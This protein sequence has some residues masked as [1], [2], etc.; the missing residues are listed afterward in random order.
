[1]NY[2]IIIPIFNEEHT[3]NKLLSELKHYYNKENEIIIVN[4]GSSDNSLTLLENVKF[5]TLINLKVNSGKGI[6]LK[7][8]IEKSKYSKI[9][10][11]DGDLELKTRDISKLMVLDKNKNT[12]AVFGYRFKS[13]SLIK[14]GYEWGNFM[15]TTFFN[16]MFATT[17][18][19]ILCC[20]KAFYRE[21]VVLEKIISEK[22]DFDIE[23]SAYLT[24]SNRRKNIKQIYLNYKR[25]N[26][27]EGKKLKVND[28]WYIL[29][30]TILSFNF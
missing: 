23:L 10:I 28:G 25:R 1:M 12:N 5:I 18:K 3:L 2:S 27:N 20:A 4:D 29:K 30:R 11:Y 15:F 24:K 17:Y 8:G 6:A 22:F 13:L 14:S 9:I 16:I 7:K 21:D 26:F 19:D